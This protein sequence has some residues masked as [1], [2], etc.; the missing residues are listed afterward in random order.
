MNLSGKLSLHLIYRS[1]LGPSPSDFTF[2][3]GP[4]APTPFAPIKTE[5][6][7]PSIFEENC[8][9]VNILT[10]TICSPAYFGLILD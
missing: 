3:L 2:Q 4:T 8:P 7:A 10:H 1:A 5:T 6:S 9:Q